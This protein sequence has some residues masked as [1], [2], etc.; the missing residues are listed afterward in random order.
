MQPNPN[1]SCCQCTDKATADKVRKIRDQFDAEARAISD[2]RWNSRVLLDD[3]KKLLKGSVHEKTLDTIE[4]IVDAAG[5]YTALLHTGEQ[6]SSS[7][8]AS[9][10]VRNIKK[11]SC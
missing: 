5:V 2:F 9:F 10:I 1:C 8:L 7:H 6:P 4:Q 11:P 3:M